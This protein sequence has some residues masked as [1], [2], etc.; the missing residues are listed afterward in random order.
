MEIDHIKPVK[1][2]GS[3]D[4]TNLI[5]SCRDCNRGKGSKLLDDKSVLAKQ[6]KQ[7]EELN[8]RREQLEL[9]MQWR[10]ELISL[11]DT[12]V[13]YAKNRFE[14]IVRYSL[15]DIGIRELRKTIKKYSLEVVLDAIE[16]SSTSYLE[17]EPNSGEYTRESVNKSFEYIARI[18]RVKQLEQKKPYMKDLFYIRGILRNR[19]SFCDKTVALKLLE[20]AYLSGASIESLTDLA[21]SVRNWTEFKCDIYEFM[22]AVPSGE[23]T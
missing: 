14:E 23:I 6:R 10:E 2:G 1:K 11:E 4:I 13:E 22:E 17:K 21:K 8:E 16:I 12:K 20:D 7:L 19:L 9:M 15:S 3:N 18:C 5:T